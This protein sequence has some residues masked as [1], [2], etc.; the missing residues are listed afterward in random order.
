M[1]SFI[2]LI[3]T[4]T[5][6]TSGCSEKLPD[7][8]NRIVKVCLEGHTYFKYKH[9]MAVKLTDNGLPVKCNDPADSK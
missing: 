1:R 9:S 6:L 7:M 2:L 3:L 4:A 8:S 5:T